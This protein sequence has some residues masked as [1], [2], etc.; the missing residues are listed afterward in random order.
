[1]KLDLTNLNDCHENGSTFIENNDTKIQSYPLDEVIKK[2]NLNFNV[3]T[4][5]FM[6]I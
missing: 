2:Y 3:K 1:M 4:H 6:I 5:I